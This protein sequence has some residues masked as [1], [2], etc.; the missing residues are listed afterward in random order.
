MIRKG[1]SLCFQNNMDF[2]YA[3][4]VKRRSQTTDMEI[5]R[6]KDK[7]FRYFLKADTEK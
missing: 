5:I 7:K 1:F 6:K 3:L 4:L 2:F